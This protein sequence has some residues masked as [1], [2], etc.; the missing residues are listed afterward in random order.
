MGNHHGEK[1]E[2]AQIRQGG[3][4]VACI[5]RGLLSISV[6][7][8][9]DF[10]NSVGKNNWKIRDRHVTKVFRYLTTG[11]PQQKDHDYWPLTWNDGVAHEEYDSHVERKTLTQVRK[12][13]SAWNMQGW[14]LEWRHLSKMISHQ[15]EVGLWHFR[16]F[17]NCSYWDCI[18]PSQEW[19]SLIAQL[20][21][22]WPTMQ[23]TRIQFLGRE[24]PLKKETSTHS[25]I[26]AW[27]IPWAE[28]PAG[29]QS[30]G[31]TRVGHDLAAKEKV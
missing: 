3:K 22:N 17:L 30:M 27:R 24:D 16:W 12:G 2:N 11:G 5:S 25:S 10:N 20:V 19:A 28:E 8:I 6:T 26:L 15:H 14:A 13:Y 9:L 23:E 18:K 1:W 31:V 7:R 4:L 29:L 21:K